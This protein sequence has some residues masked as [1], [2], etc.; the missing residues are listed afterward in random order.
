MYNRDFDGEYYSTQQRVDAGSSF[1]IIRVSFKKLMNK[2]LCRLAC[3]QS[4]VLS[5]WFKSYNSNGS[6]PTSSKEREPARVFKAKRKQ[7]MVNQNCS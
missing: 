3:Y 4:K 5:R 7:T 6:H 2:N 1:L